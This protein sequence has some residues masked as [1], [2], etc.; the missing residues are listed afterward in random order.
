MTNSKTD[1][2]LLEKMLPREYRWKQRT[3]IETD[4]SRILRENAVRRIHRE[5]KYE[6]NSRLQV[7]RENTRNIREEETE[8][9]SV[10]RIETARQNSARR[11]QQ[12]LLQRQHDNESK[13]HY[14]S[15]G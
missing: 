2:E 5:M 15:Q 13:E 8:T 12:V 1:Y 7:L 14:L 4:S 3:S 9:Q 6:R 10:R 11:R